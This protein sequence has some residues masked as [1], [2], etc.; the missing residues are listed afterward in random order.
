MIWVPCAELIDRRQSSAVVRLTIA[1]PRRPAYA[2]PAYHICPSDTIA[3]ALSGVRHGLAAAKAHPFTALPLR[4]EAAGGG[5]ASAAVPPSRPSP[6]LGGRGFARGGCKTLTHTPRFP[7]LPLG[8]GRG[9]GLHGT[10]LASARLPATGSHAIRR[11]PLHSSDGGISPMKST[12]RR[13]DNDA[14]W[15]VHDA[16]ASPG[17]T[18]DASLR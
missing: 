11:P 14:V 5:E 6:S 15:A 18:P 16:Y 1:L 9:G 4:G 17:K 10:S 3:A 12:Y 8:E 7:P 13:R 2:G